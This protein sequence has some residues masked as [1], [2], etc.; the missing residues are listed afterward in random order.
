MNTKRFIPTIAILTLV[1]LLGA[2]SRS[3]PTPAPEPT[4][5]PPPAQANPTIAPEEMPAEEET[6]PAEEQIAAESNTVH[7]LIQQIVDPTMESVPN[8]F[9]PA[10]GA[11]I[12]L[13]A[14]GNQF[15]EATGLAS[16]EEGTPVQV[17]DHFEIG[18]N[19]RCSP[20]SCSPNWKKKA[21]S[22]STIP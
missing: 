1:L 13:D 9:G 8:A 16:V 7:D 20:P 11:V 19:T 17:Y 2:C 3:E 10:P 14:P 15:L 21:C 6:A 12:R 4:A 22:P 18:S 5:A